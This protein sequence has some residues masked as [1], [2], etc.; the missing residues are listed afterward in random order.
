MRFGWTVNKGNLQLLH[1]GFV[2]HRW[3]RLCVRTIRIMSNRKMYDYARHLRNKSEMTKRFLL[4]FQLALG[5]DAGEHSL[6]AGELV[7]G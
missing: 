3:A 2:V 5:V 6:V 4:M 7:G 1:F